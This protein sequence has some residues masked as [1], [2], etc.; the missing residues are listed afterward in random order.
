VAKEPLPQLFLQVRFGQV[1]KPASAIFS[2]QERAGFWANAAQL[3]SDHQERL[4]GRH[5]AA[6]VFARCARITVEPSDGASRIASADSRHR[7]MNEVHRHGRRRRRTAP[8]MRSIGISHNSKDLQADVVVDSLALL[9]P[10][11]FDRLLNQRESR[12]LA[13]PP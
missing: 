2:H 3:R 1:H 13:N 11:A 9:E 4:K 8:G 7:T 10:Y 6:N 5:F 12:E